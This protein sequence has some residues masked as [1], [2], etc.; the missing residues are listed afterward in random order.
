[1]SLTR[2]RVGG[3]ALTPWDEITDVQNRFRQLFG[4]PFPLPRFAEPLGWSPPVD[5]SESDGELTVVAELP[6]MRREDVHI[7]LTDNLL[8]IRGEK[9]E[10]KERNE[11]EMHVFERSY[12]S[13]RRSFMLP[14]PVDEAGVKAEFK[15]GVLRVT[16]PKVERATG[17]EIEIEA[18]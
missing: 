3:T 11:K 5:V 15:N 16:L 12:G 4:T 2:S 13:F 8:T 18:G 17:R 1:M 6:G 10:E 9:K 7:D 14:T